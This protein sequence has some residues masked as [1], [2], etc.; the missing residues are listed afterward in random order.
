LKK[1]EKDFYTN[2]LQSHSSDLR[3]YWNVLNNIKK[4]D[5]QNEIVL[6]FNCDGVSVSDPKVIVDRF[7]DYFSS[8]GQILASKI[9]KTTV[10]YAIFLQGSFRDSFSLFPTNA[11]EVIN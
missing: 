8:I 4:G 7:S 10:S 5:Q 6:N 2:T 11:F 9:P 1:A 3:R